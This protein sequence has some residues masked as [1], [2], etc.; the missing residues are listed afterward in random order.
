MART[1]L[2]SERECYGTSATLTRTALEHGEYPIGVLL[3]CDSHDYHIAVQLITVITSQSQQSQGVYVHTGVCE[4]LA[5]G[6]Y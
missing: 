2:L 5:R 6:R 3:T 4:L 1:R